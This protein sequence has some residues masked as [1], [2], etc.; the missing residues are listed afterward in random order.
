MQ[1]E[2]KE[3]PQ[4]HSQYRC[5]YCGKPV[6]LSWYDSNSPFTAQAYNEQLCVVCAYWQELCRHMPLN[7]FV[8]NHHLI[9]IGQKEELDFVKKMHYV[10]TDTGNVVK[11]EII[12]DYGLIP[13]EFRSLLPNNAQ[14]VGKGMATKALDNKGYKCMRYG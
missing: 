10:L 1:V 4:R 12:N 8:I 2:F 3:T 13:D 5:S 9:S 7:S 11:G 6:D 14:F